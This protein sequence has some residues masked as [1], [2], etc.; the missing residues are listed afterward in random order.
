MIEMI[1]KSILACPETVR[2]EVEKN[3]LLAGGSTLFPGFVERIT[4][5][6]G[7][8][9]MKEKPTVVAP[10]DRLVS[11]WVGGSILS[12]LPDFREMSVTKEN[13]DEIGPAASLKFHL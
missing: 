10:E 5:A 2:H 4:T 12:T 8:L 1:H 9:E 11:S 7:D 3:L 6:L 13:Y